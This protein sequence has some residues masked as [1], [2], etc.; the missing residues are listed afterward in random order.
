M[1]GGGGLMSEVP[2][3]LPGEKA[4]LKPLG[5]H[6]A[7]L[8]LLLMVLLSSPVLRDATVYEP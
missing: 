4:A 3:Q 2:L 5:S 7:P 8:L 6:S 1:E